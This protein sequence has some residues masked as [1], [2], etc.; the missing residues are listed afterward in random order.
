MIASC[1]GT[2]AL[3]ALNVIVVLIALMELSGCALSFGE[4]TD[5]GDGTYVVG[6]SHPLFLTS[7]AIQKA[8]SRA[9]NYCSTLGKH[10]TPLGSQ[11]QTD[12]YGTYVSVRFRCD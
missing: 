4:V 3:K 10:S 8:E 12:P 2:N 6:A 1:W 7:V 9:N 11:A 5:L